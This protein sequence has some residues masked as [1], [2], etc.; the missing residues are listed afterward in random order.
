MES[1]REQILY[2]DHCMHGTAIGTPMGADLMCGWCED[3]YTKWVDDIGYTLWFKFDDNDRDT[4]V[5]WTKVSSWRASNPPAIGDIHARR[6]VGSWF[7]LF[8]V[9]EVS[10]ETM[11]KVWHKV[12]VTSKGYWDYPDS[13]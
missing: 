10:R 2:G 6:S 13:E 5:T 12:T 3:G 8:N 4:S 11:S 9:P 1:L 7:D